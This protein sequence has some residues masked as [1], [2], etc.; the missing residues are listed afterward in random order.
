DLS[1]AHALVPD[2]VSETTDSVPES[3]GSFVWDRAS[4]ILRNAS[5]NRLPSR[6][7]IAD[8]PRTFLKAL[9]SKAL[10]CSSIPDWRAESDKNLRIVF[11]TR[12]EASPSIDDSPA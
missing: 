9:V 7:R 8:L 11:L 12:S 5:T 4:E 2:S 1:S 6:C 10:S 3:S